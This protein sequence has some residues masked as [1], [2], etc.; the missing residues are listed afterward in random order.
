MTKI[1]R[2]YA[3]AIGWNPLTRLF[4]NM[5]GKRKWNPFMNNLNQCTTW[6]SNWMLWLP[7]EIKKWKWTL[8]SYFIHLWLVFLFCYNELCVCATRETRYGDTW[9]IVSPYCF[10][11]SWIIPSFTIQRFFKLEL[12]NRIPWSSETCHY[13]FGPWALST[14]TL[15]S[16]YSSHIV[17]NNLIDSIG[18]F[19]SRS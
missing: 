6:S 1:I 18:A 4:H 5:L 16:T 2:W 10:K 7:Y 17:M 3:L 12:F 15:I 8:E 14:M 11:F 19:G 9:D 13:M